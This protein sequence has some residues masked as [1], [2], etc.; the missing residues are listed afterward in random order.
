VLIAGVLGALAMFFWIF[1]A[2]MALPPGEAGI[3]QIGNEEPLLA[4]M[5]S[6]L[7]SPRH[8]HVSGHGRQCVPMK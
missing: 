5:K 1:I 3:R 8:V 7:Q 6:T 4:A 2:H